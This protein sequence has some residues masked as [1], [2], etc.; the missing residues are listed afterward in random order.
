MYS[1]M[2]LPTDIKYYLISLDQGNSVYTNTEITMLNIS[3]PFINYNVQNP[4][5]WNHKYACKN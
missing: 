5:V 1:K 3:R 4:N 2:V